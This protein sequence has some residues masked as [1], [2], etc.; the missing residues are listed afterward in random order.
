[1]CRFSVTGS[2]IRDCDFLPVGW[3]L[4]NQVQQEAGWD[5]VADSRWLFKGGFFCS[6]DEN[7]VEDAKNFAGIDIKQRATTVARI[8]GG[9]Q[10]VDGK[11]AATQTLD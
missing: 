1:M 10:L 3:S 6:F 2:T 11:R 8:G 5:G 9:I 4:G 7:H